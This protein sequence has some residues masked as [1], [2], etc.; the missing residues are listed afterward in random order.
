MTVDGRA[1]ASGCDIVALVP[2]ASDSAQL[3]CA[4]AATGT[5]TDERRSLPHAR[6]GAGPS[7]SEI[8]H[9]LARLLGEPVTLLRAN[10]LSWHKNYDASSMMIEVEPLTRT[11]PGALRWESIEG[12]DV[13]GVS[14][15][16]ARASLA[17]W[18]R[19]RES[20]W[21][22]RRPQWSRPGWMSEASTWMQAHMEAG[23]YLEPRP[24]KI[25]HLWG[26]SVVLSADALNGTAYLKCSGAHFRNE[27][28]VTRSLA[29][30]STEFRG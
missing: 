30:H 24:A 21:S 2:R 29:E 26:I 5:G 20:G 25:H 27:A 3:L 16:W 13:E 6:L 11:P 23:G 9:H 15:K 17:A 28:T 4:S 10:T 18:L 7:S 22:D 8:S 12:S 14:P 1:D 19:E